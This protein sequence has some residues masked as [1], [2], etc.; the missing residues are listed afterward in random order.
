LVWASKPSGLQFVGC[1]TKPTEREV[2]VGHT[3]RSSGLLHM[4]ASLAR[5]SHSGLKISGGAM[6]GGV[7]DTIT[8]VASESS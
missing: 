7:R 8:E 6:T 4:K 5:V 1:A 3:S 2:G